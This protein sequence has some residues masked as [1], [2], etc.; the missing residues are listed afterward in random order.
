MEIN[1]VFIYVHARTEF[2]PF[3]Q[4]RA[5]VNFAWWLVVAF[6]DLRCNKGRGQRVQYSLALEQ[7]YWSASGPFS[8]VI[9]LYSLVSKASGLKSNANDFSNLVRVVAARL[10]RI[11]SCVS[12]CLPEVIVWKKGWMF[13]YFISWSRTCLLISYRLNL[14]RKSHLEDEKNVKSH[15]AIIDNENSKLSSFF[16]PSS[17]WSCKKIFTGRIKLCCSTDTFFLHSFSGWKVLTNKKSH[18]LFFFHFQPWL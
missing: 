15:D 16:M 14:L 7:P 9:G 5:A 2:T 6:S 10:N 12:L 8:W 13:S 4:A 1:A 18:F 11:S 3:Q 17:W